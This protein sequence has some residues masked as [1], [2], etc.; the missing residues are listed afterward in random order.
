MITYMWACSQGGTYFSVFHPSL[1]VW[2]GILDQL[3]ALLG[4][5]CIH[6]AGGLVSNR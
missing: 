5:K 3:I 1:S 2:Q 4:S 6:Q